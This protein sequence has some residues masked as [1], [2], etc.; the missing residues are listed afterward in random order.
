MLVYDA[1]QNV[2]TM[3]MYTEG[4]PHIFYGSWRHTTQYT[5]AFLYDIF[6]NEFT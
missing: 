2:A 5:Y 3:N 1:R 4:V 6:T